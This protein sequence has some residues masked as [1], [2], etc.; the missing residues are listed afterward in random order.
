MLN[1]PLTDVKEFIKEVYSVNHK[2]R[3][4]F[5]SQIE[6]VSDTMELMDNC[7]RDVQII[8]CML[9]HKD[10]MSENFKKSLKHYVNDCQG[11]LVNFMHLKNSG[12][13]FA[14]IYFE[15]DEF[16]YYR[17]LCLEDGELYNPEEIIIKFA[18]RL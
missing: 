15:G 14:E 2:Y 5:I 13:M 16:D 11:E 1:T 8:V 17:L 18:S 12:L 10:K 4:E 7:Y 6:E 9:K 3:D